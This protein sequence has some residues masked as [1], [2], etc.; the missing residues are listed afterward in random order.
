[1]TKDL[2]AD[3]L[4]ARLDNS[5]ANA[6]YTP[7]ALLRTMLQWIAD[8]PSAPDKS[9]AK[10]HNWLV[11]SIV[12]ARGVDH[13]SAVPL[14]PD[15][16]YESS[17]AVVNACAPLATAN[18]AVM[19]TSGAASSSLALTNRSHSK[20]LLD[21]TKGVISLS[22]SIIFL[23]FR[24]LSLAIGLFSL[25]SHRDRRNPSYDQLYR[26]ILEQHH[27]VS[28]GGF[29]L[30]KDALWLS[31]SPVGDLASCLLLLVIHNERS[32]D[33]SSSDPTSPTPQP[34]SALI[35]W[36]PFRSELAS[37]ADS[38]WEQDVAQ[39]E[40]LFGSS[41]D[42]LEDLPDLPPMAN[43]SIGGGDGDA[44]L[45]EAL[46]P[47]SSTTDSRNSDVLTFNFEHL[48]E[49]FG[50]TAHS[51]V[52]AVLLYTLIQ[53]SQ[54]F[55]SSIA[56]R[57][58][59]D[60]IVL[61]LLRTLYFSSATQR[62]EAQD[63][64][65]RGGGGTRNLADASSA[66][67][68]NSNDSASSQLASGNQTGAISIRSCPFRSQSQLYVI[69]ILLL[70]LSQDPSFGRDAF[71]RVHVPNVLWYKEGHVKDINLGSVVLLCLLRS[72]A[73]NLNRLH[74][75]FLVSNCCAI[76]MNLS[77]NMTDLHQHAAMVL[78]STTISFMKKYLELRAK[79]PEDDDM[80]GDDGGDEAML[81]STPT[82]MR[83]EVTR[84]LLVVLKQCLSH[85]NVDRNVNLVYALMYYQ[86]DWKKQTKQK[87]R[88]LKLNRLG[89]M[90]QRVPSLLAAFG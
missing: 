3:N 55:S 71:R 43:G 53:S 60:T 37:L 9:L 90:Q 8:R 66:I 2:A 88:H 14:G 68:R 18:S 45:T 84:T 80:N 5:T 25:H 17:H 44:P 30:T 85:K 78:V 41:V 1:M 33:V 47:A 58:D 82:S 7:R 74:D 11:Q 34:P 72:L 65:S 77:P 73:F 24:L 35:R 40:P 4:T 26:Q 46:I 31:E 32:G 27:K 20:L 51:E 83:G 81:L 16:M 28:P 54:A 10:H 69:I 12:H 50:R 6:A 87:G 22:S 70:L 86:A 48:F 89:F 13:S 38:R 63:Y 36:N 64:T 59:L 56:V 19:S 57:S 67:R 79:H 29:L 15:G 39:N 52:G 42:G 23:P 61:P 76:L 21:A 49:S 75:A 62:Y